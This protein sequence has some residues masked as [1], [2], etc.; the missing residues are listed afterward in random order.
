MRIPLSAPDVTADDIEAVARVLRTPRLSLGPKLEEFERAMAAYAG[1]AEGVGLSS[2]TA[3][4]HLI[5]IALGVGP[6][7]EVVLPSFAFVA[8]A[9]AV[10]YV[11]ATPVFV[12]I[13]PV[14]L[15]LDPDAVARAV[16]ARTKAILV[17]HT[18]GY[19]ADLA[20]ILDLARRHGLRVIEDACE[21][22]GAE[23]RSRRVGGLG[24]AGVF[25]FYPNK[26]ITTGEGGMVVTNDA[27]L[28][29]TIRALRNQ[30][31]ASTESWV[32]SS[33]VGFNYRLSE[34]NCA[35]GVAQLARIE[36]ML[37]RRESRAQLYASTLS[38]VS[39]I[40]LPPPPPADGRVCWFVYVVRLA[41]HFTA[42][43]RGE[44]IRR[45]AARGIGCRDYFPALHR[46]PLFVARG[47]ASGELSATDRIATRTLALP[48]FNR[49]RDEDIADV[50]HRLACEINAC[51]NR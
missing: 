12:D 11:G 16:T 25:S 34:L 38:G 6:G 14:T 35:L 27:A 10:L 46:Q 30:G 17:V 1:T 31:R 37:V 42:E 43:D 13:D 24:D 39:G 29:A 3:G 41:E 19:P 20:P 22:I 28:A 7:D 2:G 32:G 48:L 5:L 51:Q 45:M 26:P 47:R 49:L 44:L 23:Y 33:D 40:E 21:A 8:A 36:S 4:L 18:F 9:N 50:C 15:N